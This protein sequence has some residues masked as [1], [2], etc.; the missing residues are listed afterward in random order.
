MTL[1]RDAVRGALWTIS[2][3]IGSRAI[4]LVGTLLITRFIT[5]AD[6]G[7]VAVAVVMVMTA[8]QMTTLGFGQ[9][10]VARPH[11]PRSVAFHAT[12]FHIA[13]GVLAVA[14][15]LT[16]AGR[17]GP[18]LGAQG[19]TK[20]LPG[21]VASGFLERIG[22][23][24]ERI[25][26]RDVRFGKVSAVR[27]LGDLSYSVVA[28]GLAAAGWG[29]VAI[30]MGNVV[31]SLL[32]T[33]AFIVAVER[34]DWFQPCRLSLRA[35]RELFSFG[36]PLAIAALCSFAARRWDNLLVSHFFGAETTGM[37]NLAYNLADV[38]AIQVGEQIGDVLLPSFARMNPARRPDAL[39]RSIR[40]LALVV[41]PLAIGLGAVAPTLVAV[42][43]DARWQSIAPML[44]LLSALS[45]TRPIGWTIEA[46]LQARQMPRHI[47]LLSVF[48]LLALVFVICTL[49]R[50]GPLFTCVAV[51]VAFGA[52]AIAALWVVRAL[53]GVALRRSLGSLVPAF[54]ACVPMVAAVLGVRYLLLFRD[55]PVASLATEVLAGAAAY[56]LATL[57]VARESSRE[58][59]TRVIDALGRHS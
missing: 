9:F 30:V 5:P 46:Y 50:F 20:F 44:V 15:L 57:V 6:Y 13:L 52:H 58:V 25:L 23:V 7:E 19:M 28:V 32:R 36:V 56:V 16:F 59:L 37:Y 14:L 8:N 33:A 11:T 12:T 51:G 18:S 10:L 3:G 29:G 54:A 24:P 26:V 34:R 31:R 1:V 17:L 55:S 47:L 22:Y 39:V 21:L 38:P 2:S 40:L 42:V 4:G 43:F 49:G 45:I 48:R 41:F 53:D 27:T 35:S